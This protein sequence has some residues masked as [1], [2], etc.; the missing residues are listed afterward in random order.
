M[1]ITSATSDHPIYSRGFVIG[2]KSLKESSKDI[3]EDKPKSEDKL[4][5]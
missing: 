5:K 4:K 1:S 2:G 3:P